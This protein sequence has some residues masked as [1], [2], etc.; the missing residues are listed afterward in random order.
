MKKIISLIVALAFALNV[1]HAQTLD[2]TISNHTHI[3][4]VDTTVVTAPPVGSGS[5]TT[6]SDSA[7][8][9]T[10]W[11]HGLAGDA[12][13]WSH[14]Q[15]ATEF[16]L[17]GQSIPGYP[18][19][20]TIGYPVDY[21]GLEG[22]PLL[23]AAGQVNDA[24]AGWE[25][26]LQLDTLNLKRKVAIAHSQGGL[27]A[28]G[29]RH[30]NY[31]SSYRPAR[32]GSLITMGTPH[33]GAMIINN[34]APSSGI[35]NNWITT[36]CT[37]LAAAEFLS[38]LKELPWFIDVFVNYSNIVSNFSADACESLSNTVLPFLIDGVRKPISGDY[39][40]NA[41]ALG[42]IRNNSANDTLPVLVAYGVEEDP[43]LWRVLQSMTGALKDTS[44]SGVTLMSDPFGLDADDEMAQDMSAI[45]SHYHSLANYYSN[46]TSNPWQ[47][48]WFWLLGQQDDISQREGIY[49]RA[50]DWIYY[51]NSNW[52]RS[53]GARY[54]SVYVGDYICECLGQFIDT[55]ASPTLCNQYLPNCPGMDVLQVLDL[56]TI[57]L[58]NDGVVPA[59]S[60][61]AYP[62]NI[63][64]QPIRME[65]TNHMQMR[66][67]SETKLLLNRAFD[68]ELGDDFYISKQ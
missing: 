13:S 11:I 28:T 51:A 25:I 53:I 57:D 24:I 1:S 9:M 50:G 43:V 41:S 12:S 44:I 46:V 22:G 20:R 55:V 67:S 21:S 62:G 16:Q 26:A 66:N 5:T 18:A 10:I 56:T 23:H 36:G 35:I 14:V 19:R 33:N 8:K 42:S 52:K 31:L 63:V 48:F 38:I 3:S 34:S 40:V 45:R 61:K 17:P 2:W 37:N 65:N 64:G 6:T 59:H 54:D 4:Q 49:R 30:W 60:Q 15:A 68:G 27:I 32:F 58:P 29:M 7:F 39:A 47:M